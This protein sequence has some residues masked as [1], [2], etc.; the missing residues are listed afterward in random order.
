[1]NIDDCSKKYTLPTLGFVFRS[2]PVNGRETSF[3]L[4]LTP[5]DYVL[6]F[7]VNG[8]NDCVIGIGADNEDSG[9]TLGQV[10][11]KAYYSVFDRETESI[12][13]VRS[14]PDPFKM[15]PQYLNN[16][17]PVNSPIN[18]FKEIRTNNLK[19][20][21]GK[22]EMV[23]HIVNSRVIELPKNYN[24]PFQVSDYI[25]LDDTLDERLSSLLKNNYS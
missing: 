14:N 16:S 19:K 6:E 20:S 13:F 8:K 21:K 3:E 18:K 4:I 1:M 22:E 25:N 5:D 2:F 17:P 7:D 9:W 12:G 15:K 23:K 10:F 24:G 11:L